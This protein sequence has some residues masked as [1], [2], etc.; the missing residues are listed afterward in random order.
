MPFEIPEDLHPQCAPVAWLLGRWEG[1]G[2]G[3]YPTIT[4]FSFRQEVLFAHDGRPFFHYFSRAFLTDDTGS[5]IKP[6]AI[7]TGFLRTPA[8]GVLELVLAH[9][10]G[11]VEV[12]YGHAEGA[13]IELAT[14]AVV[15]TE[16]AKEYSAGKRLYGLVDGDL[17]W[18]HD[19]AAMGQPMQSH[20][21]A[22]LKRVAGVPSD[23]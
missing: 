3:D 22:R 21:W 19:M 18:T 17:L 8:D 14:D 12:W 1:N 6:S 23:N 13:K 4:R 16:T 2:H 7:E 20:I 10:T 15:R 9:A 5:T 11:F